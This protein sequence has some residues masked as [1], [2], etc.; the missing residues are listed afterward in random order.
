MDLLDRSP[1]CW[2]GQFAVWKRVAPALQGR[3][4]EEADFLC[5]L[6]WCQLV[7]DFP[8]TSNDYS[9]HL[10]LRETGAVVAVREEPNATEIGLEDTARAS[11]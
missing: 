8:A 4:R 1:Y 11:S 6:H 2:C 5:D 3:L 9:L 7:R 10:P